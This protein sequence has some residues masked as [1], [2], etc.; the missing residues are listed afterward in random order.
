MQ[1]IDILISKFWES[2]LSLL[3]CVC[4]VAGLCGHVHHFFTG[5]VCIALWLMIRH[6][7]K[8]NT[9]QSKTR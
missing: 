9:L 6:D 5:V 7:R 3:G 4:V 8:K 2:L 1:K